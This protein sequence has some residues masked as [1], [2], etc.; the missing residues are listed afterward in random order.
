MGSEGGG[1]VLKKTPDFLDIFIYASL[2]GSYFRVSR[3]KEDD[4]H[5]MKMSPK[6][7]VFLRTLPP[8]SKSSAHYEFTSTDFLRVF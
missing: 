1:R 2:R 3:V 8:P 7:G 6:S 4:G 5:R